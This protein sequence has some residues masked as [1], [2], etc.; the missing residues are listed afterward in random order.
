MF[1]N[2]V[3]WIIVLVLWM[4]GSTWWH[5]CKIK[6]L[7][8]NEVLSSSAATNPASPP[9][10]A[11]LPAL[12]I[13]DSTRFRL[14]VPGN[15]SFA[16]SDFRANL[17]ALGGSLDSLVMYVRAHPERPLTVTGYYDPTE[18]NATSLANLGLARAEAIRRFL[19]QQGIPAGSLRTEGV[20]KS[21]L[22][23][24]PTGDS[25]Y[26]GVAFRF[27]EGNVVA[28]AS[29]PPTPPAPVTLAGPT[30]E[31]ALATAEKFTSVFKPID[32][33]FP[34]GGANYISTPDTRKFFS[35]AATYLAGHKDKKLVLTGHT[36]SAGPDA[37][38]MQLSR[39][40]ANAVKTRLRQ[41][42]IDPVQMVVVARGETQPKANNSTP[43]GRR[44]N[45]RVTVVVQ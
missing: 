16:M 10:T 30:T 26:G 36:D 32:L 14:V 31:A 37:V 12:T 11:S 28:P 41:S 5:V 35:E 6:Q 18:T 9:V 45:R 7:C 21:D 24:T 15:F 22:T 2:K 38:N 20:T 1:A 4:L 40:R 3:P 27:G 44:A 23:F 13:A 39:D 19:M 8:P 43:S 34:L 42:G 25:I 33:Y 17:N 29:P